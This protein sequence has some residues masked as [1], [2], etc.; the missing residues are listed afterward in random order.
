MPRVR[1]LVSLGHS[2]MPYT[3]KL[4]K[5]IQVVLIGPPKISGDWQLL[6]QGLE[7]SRRLLDASS[8]PCTLYSP[9]PT[10]SSP[11]SLRRRLR[12]GGVDDSAFARQQVGAARVAS[13]IVRAHGYGGA[14]PFSVTIQSPWFRHLAILLQQQLMHSV[15]RTSGTCAT[16]GSSRLMVM[17][18]EYQTLAV[19]PD[20][21]SIAAQARTEACLP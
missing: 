7:P 2:S 21:N 13:N 19:V 12:N 15:Q 18:S 8:P 11:D 9:T 20:S 14:L 4:I 6:T 10:P 3:P 1:Q 17:S 5:P 16:A